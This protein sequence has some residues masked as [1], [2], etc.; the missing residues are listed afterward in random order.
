MEGLGLEMSPGSFHGGAPGG[1]LRGSAQEEV[2]GLLSPTGAQL[3]TG[4]SAAHGPGIAP[5]CS[6]LPSFA[7]TPSAQSSGY[8][9]LLNSLSLGAASDIAKHPL[10]KVSLLGLCDAT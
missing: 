5:A 10:L 7:T 1:V 8:F 9:S 4:D 6:P 3:F 2:L